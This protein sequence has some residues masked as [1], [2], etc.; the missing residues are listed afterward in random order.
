MNSSNTNTPCYFFQVGLIVTGKGEAWSQSSKN[1]E[2]GLPRLFR[3]LTTTGKCTF[4]VVGRIG[5]R[6]PRTVTKS[7]KKPMVVG[8]DK[9]IPD[10]DTNDISLPVRKYLESPCHYVLLVDDLEYARSQM[11][12]EVFQRYRQAVEHLLSSNDQRQRV[13]VHFLVNMLEAYYFADANTINQVLGTQLQDWPGD[14]ETIRHPKNDLK[15]IYPG[16]DEIE[17]GVGEILPRLNLE[18]VLSNP[19]TCASLRTLFRWCVEKI[20]DPITHK[21]QLLEGKLSE[22]TKSQLVAHPT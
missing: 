10:K 8:T 16:F 20:G 2:D 13:A 3:P 7:P 17:H 18:H 1:R 19:E 22:V 21:Y 4:Q 5:Q 14:V 6:S 12:N 9:S 15:Q 11:A